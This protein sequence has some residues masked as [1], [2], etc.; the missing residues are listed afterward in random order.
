MIS[1]FL[2]APDPQNNEKNCSI[3][4]IL[5]IV[6][7]RQIAIHIKIFQKQFQKEFQKLDDPKLI[8]WPF[9]ITRTAIILRQN[10]HFQTITLAALMADSALT[11]Q[12]CGAHMTAA[13]TNG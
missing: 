10:N 4:A 7:I 9:S 6:Q 13:T 3:L 8:F 12:R 1:I 2:L 5:A 11:L